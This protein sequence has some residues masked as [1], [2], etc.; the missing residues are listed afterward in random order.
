MHYELVS[1]AHKAALH[2]Q[3]A[4]V[5]EPPLLHAGLPS[6]Y[7]CALEVTLRMLPA[8]G[9]RCPTTGQC[10][11][12]GFSLLPQH[13]AGCVAWISFLRWRL[14]RGSLKSFGIL[15]VSTE[16]QKFHVFFSWIISL[17]E[18]PLGS[19][20]RASGRVTAGLFLVAAFERPSMTFPVYSRRQLRDLSLQDRRLA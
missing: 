8:T 19:G 3:P 6:G 14:A 1:L 10:A 13:G 2:P 16:I 17:T 12:Q 20:P 4:V 11:L 5:V 9:L 15:Q 7:L 18:S